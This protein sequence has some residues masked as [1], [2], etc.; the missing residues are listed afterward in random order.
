M[1]VHLVNIPVSVEVMTQ[2]ACAVVAELDTVDVHH[3][4]DEPVDGWG[5]ME[6][7]ELA[8]ETLHHP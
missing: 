7:V 4:D 1:L 2:S 6:G 3:G 5:E 8:E